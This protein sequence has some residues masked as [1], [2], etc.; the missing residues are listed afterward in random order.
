VL[1]SH[2][3]SRALRTKNHKGGSGEKTALLD[4]KEEMRD[5]ETILCVIYLDHI[6][7]RNVNSDE[8]KPSLRIAIG[9]LIKD[10]PE[11][12][13]I[14]WDQSL[15]ENRDEAIQVESGLLILKN[16]ILAIMPV[17]CQPL[18]SWKTI[19]DCLRGQ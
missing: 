18:R 8:V 13:V 17:D 9:W 2:Y 3:N 12:I 10:A 1:N 14:W 6:L 7:F 5:K 15:T 16:T 11:Y 4:E 19:D